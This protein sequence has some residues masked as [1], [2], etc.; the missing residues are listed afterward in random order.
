MFWMVYVLTGYQAFLATYRTF[1]F[2]K[3]NEGGRH[4]IELLRKQ[5]TT[6]P[7]AQRSAGEATLQLYTDI[8]PVTGRQLFEKEHRPAVKIEVAK[9]REEKGTPHSQTLGMISHQLKLLWEA[10]DQDEWNDKAQALNHDT[11]N[12][13]AYVFRSLSRQ[14]NSHLC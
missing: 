7:P 5:G 12:V 3:I 2:N 4:V 10:A 14:I 6:K 11:S 8:V 9:E 1:K 13:H